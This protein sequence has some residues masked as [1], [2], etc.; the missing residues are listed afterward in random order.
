MEKVIKTSIAVGVIGLS[1]ATGYIVY[2]NKPEPNTDI[3]IP[4]LRQSAQTSNDSI[5]KLLSEAKLLKLEQKFQ[6]SIQKYVKAYELDKSSN[7]AI[8][9]IASVY[10][11]ADRQ[12]F[13]LKNLQNAEKKGPL[14]YDGKILF[15]K[16]AILNQNVTQAQQV[17]NSITEN[18]AEKLL[19]G[20][21]TNILSYD[22]AS[23]K[24]KL[25]TIIANNVS[26]SEKTT[27][28]KL[29]N[30]LS[31]YETFTDSPKSYLFAL[32]SKELIDQNLY[33]LA[34]PILFASIED[35]NDYRDAWLL[36][37]YSYLLSNKTGDAIKSLERA[38]QV[39]PYNAEIH[40][41]LGIAQQKLDQSQKALDSFQKASSFGFRN[42]K[43]NLIQIANSFYLEKKFQDALEFYIKA[44]NEG[45]IPLQDYTKMVYVALEELNDPKLGLEI[46]LRSLQKYPTAP[47]SNNLVGWA[48]IKS[49]DYQEAKRY[50]N[51]ALEINP[52]FEAAYLNLGLIAA[53][54]N[55]RDTALQNFNQAIQFANQNRAPSIR[56]RAQAEINKLNNSPQN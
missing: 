18:T 46:S 49:G 37:G 33:L 14:D 19:L 35:K 39:D 4:P 17:Y 3:V 16:L 23:A 13:T 44:E 32:I 43:D 42:S 20:A 7:L 28:E 24:S 9:G 21:I 51:L 10:Y 48:Q 26:T 53:A 11:E 55:N 41:Y 50:L 15:L 27:A 34:R 40:F 30:A 25:D 52:T 54:E 1:L 36:L 45:T 31:I 5:N 47:M 8:I 38:K 2:N 56:E 29:K 6:E 12:D 22:I